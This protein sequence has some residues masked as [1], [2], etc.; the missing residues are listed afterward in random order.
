MFTRMLKFKI[1]FQ[2]KELRRREA[3]SPRLKIA[4]MKYARGYVVPMA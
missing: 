1:D 2:F 3:A 4:G